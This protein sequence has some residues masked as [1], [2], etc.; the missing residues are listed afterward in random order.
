MSTAYDVRD[1]LFQTFNDHNLGQLGLYYSASA[2]WIGPEGV[3]E[4][5]EQIVTVY[6]QL[7]AAFPDA[8][9][10]PWYKATFSDP[11]VTEWMLTGT[12]TGPFLL[13]CGRYLEG[14]YRQIAVR[15]CCVAHVEHDRVITHQVYY[16]QLE[17]CSQLGLPRVAATVD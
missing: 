8:R 6:E 15:G 14:S 3:A 7:L 12:H 17:L 16:D 9:L 4:G 10:T 13:P 11:A 5:L 2:V 1:Q